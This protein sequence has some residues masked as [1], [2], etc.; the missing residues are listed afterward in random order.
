[1]VVDTVEG[2]GVHQIESLFHLNHDEAEIE[3]HVARSIDPEV[4]NVVVAAAPVQGL[5]VRIAK[6]ETTPEVQGLSRT[7]AGM[8]VGRPRRPDP[9]STESGR[10]PP[11]ST[12][13]A[14]HCPRSCAMS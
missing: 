4:S 2:E 1:M 8:P 3:G 11:S 5:Q 13:S 6:G 9:P 7:N 10:S 14:L 12:L